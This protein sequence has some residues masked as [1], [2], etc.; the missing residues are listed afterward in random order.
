MVIFN[1]LSP[2]RLSS[3]FSAP[4]IRTRKIYNHLYF[5]LFLMAL[6]TMSS[7]AHAEK[8]AIFIIGTGRCGS[9]CTAGLLQIMGL[10]LGEQLREGHPAINPKGFFE[11]VPTIDLTK[12]MLQELHASF[13]FPTS[14]DWNNHPKKKIFQHRIKRCLNKHFNSFSFFGIKN[15]IIALF[16]PLYCQA[17]KELGY[18]PK[19]IIIKRDLEE[20]YKSWHKNFKKLSHQEVVDAVDCYAQAIAMYASD[21]DSLE[22]NFDDVIHHTHT[23]AH[24]LKQF[25]PEL[26]PYETVQEDIAAFV[27]KNLKHHNSKHAEKASDTPEQK[28]S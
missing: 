4:L 2:L 21:Y 18:T 14:T 28:N 15:P 25:L 6:L 26:K 3:F 16:L 17:A 23:V 5:M 1:V 7:F 13:T 24:T 22:I 9:S 20:T 8:K 12:K 19:I 27:D 10:P 11:D